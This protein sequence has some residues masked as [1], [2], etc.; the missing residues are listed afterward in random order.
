MIFYLQNYYSHI[1]IHMNV[2]ILST[3]IRY[4]SLPKLYLH[5]IFFHGL[6][7]RIRRTKNIKIIFHKTKQG[8]IFKFN[9]YNT[10]VTRNV[11][12]YIRFKIYFKF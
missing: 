9:Q 1:T 6:R 12:T 7:I 2:Y 4:H 3:I 5:D 10:H 8:L 11:F